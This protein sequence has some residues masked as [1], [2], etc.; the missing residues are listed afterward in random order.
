[1]GTWL[2]TKVANA[3]TSLTEETDGQLCPGCWGERASSTHLRNLRSRPADHDQTAC[4]GYGTVQRGSGA[5]SERASGAT[6]KVSR[7][8]V[9]CSRLAARRLPA[10]PIA[11]DKWHKGHPIHARVRPRIGGICRRIYITGPAHEMKG[12][13]PGCVS[14]CP[15]PHISRR[16]GMPVDWTGLDSYHSL[17]ARGRHIRGG[18]RRLQYDDV[19]PALNPLPCQPLPTPLVQTTTHRLSSLAACSPMRPSS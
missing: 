7:S 18:R 9:A 11:S 14:P 5:R 16:R 13:W 6:N 1:M 10:D 4:A 17:H 2:H 15:F 8:P 19:V 3:T 12:P